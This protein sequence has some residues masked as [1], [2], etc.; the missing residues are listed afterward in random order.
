M[1]QEIQPH[2]FNNCFQQKQPKNT[3]CLIIFHN[4]SI[5]MAD[6]LEEI[7]FISIEQICQSNSKFITSAIYLFS[8]DDTSFYFT[9]DLVN[10]TE[11]FKYI[12]ITELNKVL[13]DTKLFI[14]ATAYHLA[15]WYY[16]NRFCGRCGHAMTAKGNE[17]ALFCPKCNFI[18]YPN[19]SPVVIVGIINK[20][21]ILLT[22]QI[23]QTYKMPALV[24]GF[25][26]IGETLEEAVKREVFEEVGLRIKNIRYYK[27]QPW[28]FSQSVLMGFFAD[29]DSNKT[30]TIDKNE[31]SEAS[32]VSREQI[33]ECE[34]TISL[35][36]EM[37]EEF[38]K[39]KVKL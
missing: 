37:I 26:E 36:A 24:S 39:N 23:N 33:P 28:A 38:R 7:Q 2:C 35:T 6:Y 8:I 16:T 19:I 15:H 22:R 4:E 21:K 32:W 14:A 5:L 18:K 12:K 29:L 1:L 25:V 27:S 3:D 10:E 31:L 11:K 34:T 17:R 30:V 13:S 9:F 20:D